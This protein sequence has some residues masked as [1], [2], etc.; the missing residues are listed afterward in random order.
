MNLNWN[1]SMA[2]PGAFPQKPD[3]RIILKFLF[4]RYFPSP[5]LSFSI[6]YPSQTKKALEPLQ[7]NNFEI[8]KYKNETLKK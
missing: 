2:M 7:S 5:L 3:G 6:Q 8:K 4:L 1:D